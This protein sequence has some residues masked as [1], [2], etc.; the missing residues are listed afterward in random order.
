LR[1]A[2][3]VRARAAA[4]RAD[5]VDVAALRADPDELGAEPAADERVDRLLQV[6]RIRADRDDAPAV[7]RPRGL[8]VVAGDAREL[9]R[10][11][12]VRAHPHDV[13]DAVVPRDVGDL[14]AIRRPGRVVLARVLL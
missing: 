4:R 6:A 2:G 12:A 10:P 3:E 8:L 11:P 5:H 1:V 7:R 9:H 13:A 14:A